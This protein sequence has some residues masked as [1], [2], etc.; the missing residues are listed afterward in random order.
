MDP[1]E[2]RLPTEVWVMAQVRRC[3][4]EGRPAF[5]MR[6]GEPTGGLVMLKVN[7]LDGTAL[8]TLP[9]LIRLSE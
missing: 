6:K 8:V 5:V 1:S 4:A 7:R 9:A 2:A 3:H